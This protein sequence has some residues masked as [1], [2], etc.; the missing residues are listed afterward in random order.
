M[1]RR[2][3]QALVKTPS[4][5]LTRETRDGKSRGF[6]AAAK[7]ANTLRAYQADWRHFEEWARTEGRES[8]P[9]SPETVVA[10]LT[11]LADVAKVSTLERRVAS[12]S[13]A[14]Q[15]AKLESPT[16]TMPVRTLMA[17]IRR[18]KGVAPKT[19]RP[20]MTDDLRAM[21]EE[22]PD[23]LLGARDRAILLLGFAGGFRRSELVG[24]DHEDLDFK[25]KGLV[26]TLRRSKTDQEGAGRKVG[27]PYGSR[28]ET[29]PVHA[30][31]A[32]LA[33]SSIESGPVFRPV[34]RHGVMQPNRLTAQSVGLIVKRYAEACGQEA[35][36][37][38]GH[39]LRS[40]HATQAA[41]NGASERAIMNQTGHRSLKM[42]RQYIRQGSL[43]R[44]NA[45]AKL[46][47]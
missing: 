41:Q 23:G 6:I 38:G 33:E 12:I 26:V 25:A 15:M 39:S 40:G 22:L 46:D 30:M 17:G 37:F 42:V 2:P 32:W 13:Q 7:S 27:I 9:A 8:L 21:L 47:L 29:C 43:F 34:N 45:A 3:G 18:Q 1:P 4:T 28:K 44:E 19:K 10:Y 14:H 20:I 35:A 11:D 36:D 16:R 5:E 24:L 31:K